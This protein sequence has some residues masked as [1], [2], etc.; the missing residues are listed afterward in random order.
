MVRKS[1]L[2]ALAGTLLLAGSAAVR[3]A[4]AP[5]LSVATIDQLPKPLPLPY[6]VEADANAQV[7]AAKAQ[8]RAAHKLLLIDMGGNWCL[9]C[10]ILAGIMAL[11]E[12]RPFLDAHYVEVSV[13]I[14]RMDKNL[15]IA[16]HYGVDLKGGV[17]ALLIV[18]PRTDRRVNTG[19]ISA[20][21]N[22]RGMT[23]QALADW[24]AKWVG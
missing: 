14:G 7:A 12:M 24:L 17:P 15:Q 13:D 18:D 20:L 11:P 1:I 8:A 2:F 16:K 6:N 21:E 22:A 4:T 3:A 19:N 5:H 9:D 23:P 10:R